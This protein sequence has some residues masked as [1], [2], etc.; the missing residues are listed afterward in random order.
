[1]VLG[2]PLSA[3]MYERGARVRAIAEQEEI[4]S[5]RCGQRMLKNRQG[6]QVWQAKDVPLRRQRDYKRKPDRFVAH[7]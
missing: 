7:K 6:E 1:M 4:C 5:R 3:E 2:F